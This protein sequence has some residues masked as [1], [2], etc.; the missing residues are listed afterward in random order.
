MSRSEPLSLVAATQTVAARATQALSAAHPPGLVRIE[1]PIV[2]VDP[3]EWLGAQPGCTQYYW[4]AR[5]ERQ[6][7]AGV[8]EAD[9]LA[10]PGPGDVHA[11]F[12]KM[13]SLMPVASR[14]LRYYGGF[15][16]H[17]GPVKGARWQ[18]FGDYR[19]VVPRFEVTRHASGSSFACNVKTGSAEANSATLEEVLAAL[20]RL[21]LG[22]GAWVCPKPVVTAREDVP[23]R[24]LWRAEVERALAAIKART[25]SKV[26]LARETLFTAR[27]KLDPVGLLSQLLAHTMHAYAFCFHPARDRAFIGASPERLFKRTNCYLESEALAGTRPRGKSDESD[28]ALGQ[29][30]LQNDK[31]CREHQ[32]VV[33]ALHE[34]F[35]N[36]CRAVEVAPAPQLLRL[37]NCQHLYTPMQGVLREV[38]DDLDAD[39]ILSLHPT[40]AVG[41]LPRE[42]ALRW[43]AGHEPFDR[44]IYAAPVGWVGL[45][46]AEF[47]VAL[48]SGLV[49]GNELALYNG[50]GIV[51]GSDPDEEWKEIETK[52]QN[53]L[54]VLDYGD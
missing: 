54:S 28:R 30:L 26:V 48:R 3:L 31:E 16:F 38:R 1:V 47:C 2:A 7:M 32:F 37:M 19:F 43:I 29:E 15:R 10:P 34:H 27:E 25:L 23:D 14:A 6:E 40:P 12:R 50:A 9:V 21:E 17:P 11:L 22:A 41:G 53:F 5:D 8:G 18:A 46:G 45:D 33:Q 24:E 35:N 13:R 36:F 42:E 52:M 39:L 51:R 44:G 20:A 4:S 49:R